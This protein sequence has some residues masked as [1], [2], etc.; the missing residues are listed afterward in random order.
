MSNG[1]LIFVVIVLYIA[2]IAVFSLVYHIRRA[3][4]RTKADRIIAGKIQ[5]NATEIDHCIK[6]LKST[7]AWLV[8]G[9]IKDQ[10]RIR[11]LRDIRNKLLS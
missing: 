11:R 3:R 2:F 5:T 10:Q 6:F 8:G 9:A 4:T 1:M 7:D